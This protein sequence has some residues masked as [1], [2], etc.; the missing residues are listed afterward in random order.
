MK[1]VASMAVASLMLM[2]SSPLLTYAQS[3]DAQQENQEAPQ[4]AARL[5]AAELEALAAEYPGIEFNSSIPGPYPTRAEAIAQLEALAA[6][7]P[8]LTEATAGPSRSPSPR[9]ADALR[10]S[11]SASM[12]GTAD[13]PSRD[14]RCR[15]CLR[16]ILRY[17]WSHVWQYLTLAYG[18]GDLRTSRSMKLSC[19]QGLF[20]CPPLE[21]RWHGRCG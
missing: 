14:R 15:P 5:T 9:T 4:E 3:E 8:A 20:R 7:V 21:A 17:I 16:H 10:P 11:G 19:A 18:D 1:I 13:A 2:S 12:E 6:I